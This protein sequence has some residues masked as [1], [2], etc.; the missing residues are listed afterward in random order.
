[1]S[2]KTKT[3]TEKKKIPKGQQRIRVHCTNDECGWSTQ[4]DASE[5]PGTCTEC[6]AKMMGPK[7]P[8]REA[9][10]EELKRV[11]VV[12]FVLPSTLEWLSQKESAGPTAATILDRAA[13]R[14]S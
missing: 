8:G 4:R 1:M 10:P 13:S 3:K 2:K 7:Q 6:G 12:A 5:P 9:L 11:R 14:A